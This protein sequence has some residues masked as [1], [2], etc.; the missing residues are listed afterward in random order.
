MKFVIKLVF[1]KVAQIEY[2]ENKTGGR[3][4]HGTVP[5]TVANYHYCSYLLQEWNDANL[6]W[7]TTE[8]GNVQ[9]VRIPPRYI[10][11]PDLLMYNR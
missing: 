2:F 9:D 5:L 4:L 7:N 1:L 6:R 3:T 8:Y 10:W 11:T